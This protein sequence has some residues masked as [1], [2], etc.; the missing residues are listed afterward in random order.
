[1]LW[2]GVLKDISIFSK[3]DAICNLLENKDVERTEPSIKW[4]LRIGSRFSVI[5]EKLE[6]TP[7]TAG[8]DKSPVEYN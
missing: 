4:S 8:G 3:A 2:R 1:M 5:T 6:G 7:A